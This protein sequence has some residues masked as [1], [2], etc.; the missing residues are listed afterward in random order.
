MKR[1]REKKERLDTLRPLD[2]DLILRLH[3]EMRLL[4]TYHSN[5]IEG[6]TLTLSETKLV[7]EEGITIGGKTLREH[8]E[9]TNN[10]R[11]YDLI[12]RLSSEKVPIN[13]VTIQ[14]IHEV[15]TRGILETA[16]QYRTRNVRITGAP[17]TPPDWKDVIPG[18]DHLID[19]ISR[20]DRPVVEMSAFL[21]HRFVAIHPFIDGNGRIARL[22]GNLFLLRHGYPPIVLEQKNR[23]QYYR[24]LR[25]AD[26]GNPEP[27][28]RFIA[29]AVSASLTRYL[30]V[31]GGESSLIPL[32]E[33]AEGS[34][35]SQEYLSLAAR[36]GLLDAVKVDSTWHA[37]REALARYI[38][39]HGRK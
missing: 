9:A 11:G 26:L 3:D 17:R 33:L 20:D 21:H 16:G 1:I 10:A 15:V 37:S 7:L 4:H 5:A 29:G 27:F 32:R 25:D 30:A 35:Y 23:L 18:M 8:L 28:T 24:A 13:H 6:N 31:A 12:A 22:L 2:R 34:P 14:Q 19:G 36:K 38:R 39:K